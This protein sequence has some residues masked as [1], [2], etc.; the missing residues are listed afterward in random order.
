M[1]DT[2]ISKLVSLPL[3]E[4]AETDLLPIVD[5][6]ASL[7]KNITA[8]SLLEAP[9][10]LPPTIPAGAI[11]SAGMFAAGV[12]S[13]TAI[14]ADAV[15]TDELLDGSVD[16]DKLAADIPGSFLL[17]NSVAGT[18]LAPAAFSNG[19]VL[20]A[21]VAGIDNTITAGTVSG[22]TYSTQG[23]ITAA[24]ALAATDLPKATAAAIGGVSVPAAGGLDV[25]LAGA[26]TIKNTATAG[27]VSGITIDAHGSVTAMVDLV[28]SDLPIAEAASLGGV[29]VPTAGANPLTVLAD[30]S[31]QHAKSGV[32]PDTYVLCVVDEYGH[33]TAGSQVLGVSNV[34][35]LPATKITS[36]VFPVDGNGL[37][38]AIADASVGMKH[39]ADY[40]VTLIQDTPPG[41]SADYHLGQ[42]WINPLTQ[43]E[44]MYARGS[45]GD[46]WMP[47]GLTALVADNIRWL[48]T[49]D[50]STG[51]VKVLTNAGVSEGYSPGNSPGIVTLDRVGGYFIVDV[52]GA[53]I[54]ELSVVGTTLDPGDWLLAMSPTD[55]GAGTGGWTRIDSMYGGS[56]GGS[57]YLDE[58]LDV[59]APTVTTKDKQVLGFDSSTNGWRAY[60]AADA[61]DWAGLDWSAIDLSGLWP[62]LDWNLAPLP[63][64]ALDDLT[65]V[66]LATTA[67]TD[68]Q[69]LVYDA[70]NSNWIPGAGGGGASI[71]DELGDCDTTTAAPTDGQVLTWSNAVSNWVPKTVAAGGS[72]NVTKPL[73]D[74][75][76]PGS[77]DLSFDIGTLPTLALAP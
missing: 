61:I 10:R 15:G 11:D 39:L 71:L 48:G 51:L 21:G 9:W 69:A 14:G 55:T 57:E 42:R 13:Q 3:A 77:A 66:D 28:G 60:D 74:S 36:D 50:A 45:A 20:T 58:L 27:T 65:D 23:L 30:G 73:V 35:D 75:G 33:I 8:K 76:S 25:D 56:G 47:I 34:P 54:N 72:V 49:V 38:N 37:T 62:E 53:A 64:M 67:P 40:S 29:M 17:D 6:S 24:A 5:V 16:I 41:S 70:I 68:G 59:D 18:K 19:L 32:T 31:L 4:V 22:I 52:G 63:P 12:V 46:Y 7:T 1:A 44:H 26:I 43:Q 2:E